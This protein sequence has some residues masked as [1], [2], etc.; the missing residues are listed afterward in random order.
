MND[1][2]VK[3]QSDHN[4]TVSLGSNIR[5][6]TY[7]GSLEKTLNMYLFANNYNNSAIY[8]QRQ[9]AVHFYIKDNGTLVR[10]LVPAKYGNDVGM[11]DTVNNQFYRS[12][13]NGTNFIAGPVVPNTVASWHTSFAANSPLDARYDVV[14]SIACNATSGSANTAA[15]T[16]QLN[17]NGW[18]T[19]G[20]N[21]WCHID[22]V[23]NQNNGSIGA[24]RNIWVWLELSSRETCAAN[25][26][27]N[28]ATAVATGDND[29]FR[30]AISGLN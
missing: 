16:A 12:A 24:G 29:D 18:T 6:F 22:N 27:A 30:T 28:C 13:V 26:A 15:T 3:V 14:G 21:C 4:A 1:F 11:Y 17:A 7:S 19:N 25:C 23:T 8:K 2:V 10:D 20:A 5:N 9:K